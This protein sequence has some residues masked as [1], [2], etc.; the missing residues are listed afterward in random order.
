MSSLGN[1]MTEILKV[2]RFDCGGN[3]WVNGKYDKGKFRTLK[4]KASV[5][6]MKPN[7]I[8]QLPEH[9]RTSESL[10]IYTCDRLFTSDESQQRAADVVHHDGKDFEI[11]SVANWAIGTCIPHY[12][13]IAVKID[14]QGRGKN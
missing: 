5:Q 10:K 14:G 12:K 7:E 1:L 13:A 3:G 9:R 6:P 4:I 2:T 11:H 8:L